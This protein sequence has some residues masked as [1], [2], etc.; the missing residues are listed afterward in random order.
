M[1]GGGPVGYNGEKELILKARAKPRAGEVTQLPLKAA[2]PSWNLDLAVWLWCQRLAVA[3][4]QYVSEP[5][6]LVL[7]LHIWLAV[8]DCGSMIVLVGPTV[9]VDYHF[10][11]L[12][13]N[14]KVQYLLN[15]NFL[16]LKIEEKCEIKASL[17]KK[18]KDVSTAVHLT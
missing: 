7:R 14:N 5:H 18:V 6:V 15:K 2:G 9:I 11:Y 1:R 8:V 16:S 4:N 3:F 12:Q 10:Y 17:N 13:K